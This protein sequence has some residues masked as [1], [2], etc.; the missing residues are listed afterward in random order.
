M[1]EGTDQARTCSAGSQAVQ[2]ASEHRVQLAVPLA[3]ALLDKGLLL[4]R[5]QR[6]RDPISQGPDNPTAMSTVKGVGTDTG[7]CLL[8]I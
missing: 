6:Q 8:C 2:A 1:S 5:L 4:Q 3:G 7:R